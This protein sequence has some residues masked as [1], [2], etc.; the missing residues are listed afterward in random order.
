MA[1]CCHNTCVVATPLL[2]KVPTPCCLLYVQPSNA[3]RPVAHRLLQQL[4][5]IANAI[6]LSRSRQHT[7][8]VSQHS[9]HRM[10]AINKLS[11]GQLSSSVF[12]SHTI[13]TR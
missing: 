13:F 5:S 10:P 9:K 2:R 7:N 8:K 4:E 3:S 12:T 11:L 6:G 1:P